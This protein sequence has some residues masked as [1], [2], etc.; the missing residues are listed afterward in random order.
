[1]VDPSVKSVIPHSRKVYISRTV[2]HRRCQY[3]MMNGR[4]VPTTG[5]V[6]REAYTP[7][8]HTTGVYKA[9]YPSF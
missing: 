6:Y 3:S 7:R 8:R 1:M 4:R 9:V 2:V 5:G